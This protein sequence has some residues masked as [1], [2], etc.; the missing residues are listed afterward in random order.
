M[1]R[2]APVVERTLE[3]PL[4]GTLVARLRQVDAQL[5]HLV[6]L[7]FD[8]SPQ[9]S[10]A[11]DLLKHDIQEKAYDALVAMDPEMEPDFGA[12][13]GEWNGPKDFKVFTNAEIAAFGDRQLVGIIV[14]KE[15]R[16]AAIRTVLKGE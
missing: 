8:A 5:A 10:E 13:Q 16:A 1:P 11:I 6:D 7:I 12:D 9:Q 3:I 4:R 14:Q 15:A 2:K